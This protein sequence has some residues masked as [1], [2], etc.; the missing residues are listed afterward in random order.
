MM[1]LEDVDVK[2]SHC[3]DEELSCANLSSIDS[4]CI[5]EV[6]S[7]SGNSGDHRDRL[8]SFNNHEVYGRDQ[9]KRLLESAYERMLSESKSE[10][11]FLEG[12]SGTGKTFLVEKFQA[13]V[14]CHFITGRFDQASSNIPFSAIIAAL[15]DLCDLLIQEKSST[16]EDL[17]FE[18]GDNNDLQNHV[19]KSIGDLAVDFLTRHVS[20]FGSWMGIRCDL[21]ACSERENSSSESYLEDF[22]KCAIQ[23]LKAITNFHQ[24][25]CI[26]LDDIHQ[27]DTAS[28]DLIKDIIQEKE[29]NNLL[30]INS[31]EPMVSIAK[32][33]EDVI[34]NCPHHVTKISTRNLDLKCVSQ[35]L[36]DILG[37]G[38]SA[39][40]SLSEVALTKTHGNV[41]VNTQL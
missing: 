10:V 12:E 2:F 8:A 19:S 22:K 38:E 13:N 1:R 25:L 40:W 24:R 37:K 39:V 17:I 33:F 21:Q 11:I 9:E 26:F 34:S 16:V 36:S 5:S 32:M 6:S 35:I 29:V 3:E 4:C 15:S 7:L 30:F 14:E 27:A 20:N 28:I 18:D 41:C 31:F 23:F